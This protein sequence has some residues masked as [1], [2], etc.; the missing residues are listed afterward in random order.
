MNIHNVL[1]SEYDQKSRRPENQIRKKKMDKIMHLI[2]LKGFL[3]LKTLI[4]AHTST[5]IQFSVPCFPE[6][7]VQQIKISL[8]NTH[9]VFFV[10]FCIPRFD[11]TVPNP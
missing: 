4:L 2:C 11:M 7:F 6:V 3:G 5:Y 8:S 1:Q 10:F 9:P